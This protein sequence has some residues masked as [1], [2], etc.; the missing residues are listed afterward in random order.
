MPRPARLARRLDPAHPQSRL[1][2]PGEQVLFDGNVEAEGTDFFSLGS[3]EIS[4]DGTRMLYGIDVAGD[5]RYT[6]RVRDLT[7]GE[8]LADEIPDT[9]SGATFLADGRF[10]VYTTVDDAWR[11]DTVWLHEIGTPVGDDVKL[12]HEPDDRYWVGADFTRSDR[13]LMIEMGS[14]ITSEEWILDADD[15]RGEP[16]VVWPRR[17]GIEYSSSHAVVDGEDVLYIL[18]NDGALDFELVR[19]SASDPRGPRETVIAHRTGHR[20]LGVDTFRDWGVIGYRREGLARLGM[21][22]YADGA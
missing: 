6:V 10:I 13:F 14:S 18:H 17:E 12:F 20:L 11:P 4:N 19:V 8:T 16:R 3:F 9:F 15:L 7:S 5:E 22:S 21:L 1:P 2:R